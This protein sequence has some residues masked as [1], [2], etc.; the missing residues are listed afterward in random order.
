MKPKNIPLTESEYLSYTTSADPRLLPFLKLNLT[1]F[2]L[3]I[4]PSVSSPTIK[5]EEDLPDFECGYCSQKFLIQ[6]QLE[7]HIKNEHIE[8]VFEC[9][10]CDKN[11]DDEDEL[12]EHLE[13]HLGKF[14]V[15]KV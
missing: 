13:A 4:D 5:K 15:I 11:F 7:M 1:I 3:F 6:E 14:I 9:K 2:L 8:E 12:E 10:Y